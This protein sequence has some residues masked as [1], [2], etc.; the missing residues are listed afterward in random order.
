[1]EQTYWERFTQTGKVEDYL[2]YRGMEIC[3]AVMKQYEGDKS[4]SGH[5]SDRHDPVGVA[6]GRI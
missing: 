6:G 3:C 5:F 1:M 2:Q 4:E